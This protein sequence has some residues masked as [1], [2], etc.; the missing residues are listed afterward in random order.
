MDPIR[1]PVTLSPHFQGGKPS[2]YYVLAQRLF[3]RGAPPLMR[4]QWIG[5]SKNCLIVT[6]GRPVDDSS[7][8]SMAVKHA[9]I[10]GNPTSWLATAKLWTMAM[11]FKT[12]IP[13][14]ILKPKLDAP[15]IETTGIFKQ[16]GEIFYLTIPKIDGEVL[17]GRK[18]LI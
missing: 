10:D 2:G 7:L 16:F 15:K 1:I 12:Y 9:V 8:V 3:P 13:G 5:F 18:E 11:G 4:Y 6:V 14:T 17:L